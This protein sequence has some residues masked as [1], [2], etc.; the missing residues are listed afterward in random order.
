MNDYYHAILARFPGATTPV[1]R[2]DYRFWSGVGDLTFGGETYA[3]AGDLIA[4]GPS[5]ASLGQSNRRITASISVAENTTLRAQL[6]EDPGPLTVTLQ[7]IYSTDQIAWSLVS[8][9]FVGRLSR[10]V[11]SG[12]V[13]QIELETY[14]G[15]V[16]RGR[17]LRWSHA[18]QL[19]RDATD[20]GFE[21][22]ESLAGGLRFRWPP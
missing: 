22:M 18:D 17:P 9:K 6:M 3:G 21:F 11:I 4:L 5:E 14:Q 1:A 10:P 16:D 7:W 2:P 12:G 15:D 20:K 13:Y 8:R 19:A